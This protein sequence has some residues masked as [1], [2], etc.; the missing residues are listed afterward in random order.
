MVTTEEGV[1]SVDEDWLWPIIVD[2]PVIAS[3]VI[4]WVIAI[5][6][7]GL[8]SSRFAAKELNVGSQN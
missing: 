4:V 6:N 5:G 8:Y 1:V 3:A 2:I 7:S